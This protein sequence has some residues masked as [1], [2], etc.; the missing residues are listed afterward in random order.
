MS[1]GNYQQLAKQFMDLW[2]EHMAMVMTDKDFMRSFLE[3]MKNMPLPS[4]SQHGMNSGYGYPPTHNAN[5]QGSPESAGGSAAAM[6]S[7]DLAL[8]ACQQRLAACEQ[9][10][11]KLESLLHE[12]LYQQHASATTA[13][14]GAGTRSP[15]TVKRPAKRK[16]RED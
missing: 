7:Y 14:L 4:Q 8:A 13:G 1:Q 12:F 9:R 5:A 2:Q 3:L 6:Q 16:P 11:A 10:I 15:R